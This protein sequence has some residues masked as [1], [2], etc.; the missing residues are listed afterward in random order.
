M[1]A[2]KR[3]V[4]PHR[5]CTVFRKSDNTNA[6]GLRGYWAAEHEQHVPQGLRVWEFATSEDLKMGAQELPFFDDLSAPA[7]EIPEIKGWVPMHKVT[8]FFSKFGKD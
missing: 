8:E 2:I 7:Y 6:F 3:P 1:N 4:I 5:M